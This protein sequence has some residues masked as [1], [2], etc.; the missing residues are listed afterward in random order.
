[1][2]K[3][4]VVVGMFGG[5]AHGKTTLFATL[6]RA[7]EPSQPWRA[8]SHRAPE[9]TRAHVWE[10]ERCM[11]TLLDLPGGMRR[12]RHWL[13]R[14]AI[15]DVGLLVLSAREGLDA[16]I[17][18]QLWCARQMGVDRWIVF[19]NVMEFA[20]SDPP[21]LYAREQAER[22]LAEPRLDAHVI[23]GD[24]LREIA[25]VDLLIDE[26]GAG[27]APP[28][29]GS[30]LIYVE[31]TGSIGPRAYGAMMGRLMRGRLHFSGPPPLTLYGWESVEDVG[32]GPVRVF[33]FGSTQEDLTRRSGD[34]F[35]M[36][37]S[38]HP[39]HRL[40]TGHVL[41]QALSSHS[42]VTCRVKPLEHRRLDALAR[43]GRTQVQVYVHCASVTARVLERDGDLLTLE[44]R[45][46][47]FLEVGQRLLLRDT[48]GTVGAG[49]VVGL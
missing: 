19:V 42:L 46:E 34:Y 1:M 16:L 32:S 18:E 48:H 36:S 12:P 5:A 29:E 15:V 6:R 24:A 27:L 8:L 43:T 44:L 30:P 33:T 39:R 13:T 35:M 2:T 11:V 47:V 41:G 14:L 25:S 38:S 37:T 26:L 49:E 17:R 45:H 23:L 7:L 28:K 40:R 10:G 31:R 4:N 21:V 3:R 9:M 20:P 22:W